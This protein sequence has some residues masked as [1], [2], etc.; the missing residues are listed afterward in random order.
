MTESTTVLAWSSGRWTN[1]PVAAV[2][3]GSELLVTAA[4]GSDAWRTTS[5]GFVHACFRGVRS[6]SGS[7]RPRRGVAAQ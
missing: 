1:P 6:G 5:Y 3:R 7:V 2:E 4:E